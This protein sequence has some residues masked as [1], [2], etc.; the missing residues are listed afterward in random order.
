MPLKRILAHFDNT[1][2][3]KRALD[4]ALELANA[5]DAHLIGCGVESYP[6]VPDFV[7]AQVPVEVYESIAA[8]TRA[9]LE[10]ARDAFT[11]TCRKAGREDRSEWQQ[12]R[13]DP[14]SALASAARCVD[15]I[16]IGQSE[17]DR[18]PA[19]IAAL[20]DDLVLTAGR[21]I[22]T[23]P[24][25]GVKKKI[26]Q[27]VLVAW[28]DTRESA[29]AVM[30]AL[31]ILQSARSVTLLTVNPEDEFSLPGADIA[32]WLAEHG[33][34]TELTR[35]TADSIDIADAILNQVS[36]SGADLIVMGGYGH[37]RLRETVLGG[38]T[39]TILR[40]MTVPTLLAH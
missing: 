9:A 12:V 38:T 11:E 1:E 2:R 26:G 18:D 34:E 6:T 32:R 21:P 16:V 8:Q 23:V 7:G 37:S 17:P 31:P 3:S 4:A 10:T 13:G 5:S 25:I 40:Q 22:L 39:R 30:D 29:R 15:L 28:S 36:E 33:V 24:Y 20:P 35:M 14:A 27:S 19:H